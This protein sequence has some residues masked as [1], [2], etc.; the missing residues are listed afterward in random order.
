MQKTHEEYNEKKGFK[1]SNKCTHWA[2]QQRRKE[3]KEKK[4]TTA[5]WNS[6]PCLPVLYFSPEVSRSVSNREIENAEYIKISLFPIQDYGSST[7]NAWI[8]LKTSSLF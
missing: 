7:E 2:I 1:R 8:I 4:K 6:N 5:I 3:K